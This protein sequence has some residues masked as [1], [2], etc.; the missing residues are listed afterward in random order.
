MTDCVFFYV[1]SVIQSPNSML[2]KRLGQ[3]L[4]LVVCLFSFPAHL[5]LHT[6][7]Q[8]VYYV[9]DSRTLFH[10]FYFLSFNTLETCDVLWCYICTKA[11]VCGNRV[12]DCHRG[13]AKF[14]LVRCGYTQTKH[15]INTV[16]D[17]C[18]LYS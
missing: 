11:K 14:S 16:E 18:S 15:P 7:C 10:I 17:R 3:G 13:Q 1:S 6:S 2:T 8:G 5:I 4:G 12:F 9:N